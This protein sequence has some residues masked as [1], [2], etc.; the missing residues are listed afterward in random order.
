MHE[1]SSSDSQISHR[2]AY[3]QK[4][5]E[6]LQNINSISK[7]TFSTSKS[8]LP[9]D[10]AT[11]HTT[12]TTPAMH[13]AYQNRP[14]RLPK[15]STRDQQNCDRNI[16]SIYRTLGPCVLAVSAHSQHMQLSGPSQR[17]RSANSSPSDRLRSDRNVTRTCR[18]QK[19][20]RTCSNTLVQRVRLT[21]SGKVACGTP[22]RD[23][24]SSLHIHISLCGVDTTL[25][26][27]LCKVDMRRA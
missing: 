26:G 15:P 5:V 1:H 8:D 12:N 14:D 21:R 27:A 18:W 6:K 20:R 25:C 22:M 4:N 3:A 7:Y 16:N 24:D 17:A 10:P 13:R 19:R 2:T 9:T 23:H 11:V